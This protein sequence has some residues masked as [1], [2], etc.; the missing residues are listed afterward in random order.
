MYTLEVCISWI[1]TSFN[2]CIE[3]SLHKSCNTTTKNSLLTEE[4]SLCLCLECWQG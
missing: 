4:V 1:V 2:K 3:T